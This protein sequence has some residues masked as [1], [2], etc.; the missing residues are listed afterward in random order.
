MIIKK[1]LVL[2]CRL[3]NLEG[4]IDNLHDY[5]ESCENEKRSDGK[6]VAPNPSIGSPCIAKFTDK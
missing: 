3:D 1:F 5:L 6:N 4:E 2:L